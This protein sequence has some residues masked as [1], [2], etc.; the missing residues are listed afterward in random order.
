MNDERGKH[1]ELTVFTLLYNKTVTIATVMVGH[2]CLALSSLDRS[3][4]ITS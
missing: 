3:R 4:I 2:M 1:R